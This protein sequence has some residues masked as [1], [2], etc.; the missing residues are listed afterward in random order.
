[1]PSNSCVR[2]I[3][4]HGKSCSSCISRAA[5]ACKASQFLLMTPDVCLSEGRH[6]LPLCFFDTQCLISQM[7]E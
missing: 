3:R 5:N 2:T 4:V 6:V 1:M 7:A